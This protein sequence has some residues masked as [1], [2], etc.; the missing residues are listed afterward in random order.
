MKPK[1]SKSRRRRSQNGKAGFGSGY[2]ARLRNFQI[3]IKSVLTKFI[4]GEIKKSQRQ[5]FDGGR[6]QRTRPWR[7]G[8]LANLYYGAFILLH[9][10]RLS[11]GLIASCL[12]LYFIPAYVGGTRVTVL[13]SMYQMLFNTVSY[14]TDSALACRPSLFFASAFM[15]IGLWLSPEGRRAF[16][17]WG[18]WLALVSLLLNLFVSIF[19]FI[20]D[21]AGDVNALSLQPGAVIFTIFSPLYFILYLTLPITR[22]RTYCP[23][24]KKDVKVV[25]Q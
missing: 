5:R 20:P 10:S 23:K 21:V 25:N 18:F 16:W 7:I 6:R 22:K 11:C 9:V 1:S 3:S 19:I 2:W 17:A 24:E 14:L 8:A 15:S 4:N 13:V 12:S